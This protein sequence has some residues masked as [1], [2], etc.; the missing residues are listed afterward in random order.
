MEESESDSPSSEYAID[1]N[2]K[3]LPDEIWLHIFS[4]LPQYTILAVIPFVCR[5]FNSLAFD[6]SLW[7]K[8]NLKYSN[9]HPQ[10][11]IA[12]TEVLPFVIDRVSQNARY[13]LFNET[14]GNHVFSSNIRWMYY[15]F[16]NIVHLDVSECCIINA[17]TLNEIRHHC[18]KI[19]TLVLNGCSEV[20]DEA[21]KVVSKFVHLTKLDISE[22]PRITDRGVNFIADMP[23]QILHFLSYDVQWISDGGIVNLVIKQTNIETLVLHGRN[24]TDL[25]VIAACQCLANLKHFRISFCTELTDNSMYALCGKT[26]LRRLYL[27]NITN[28]VSTGAFNLL[29]RYKPLLN[30]TELGICHADAVVD[31]TVNAISSG[32]PNLKIIYLNWCTE[33]TDQSIFNLI[34][35]CR[36]LELLSVHGLAKLKGSWLVGIDHFLP[37]LKHL[38]IPFCGGI[39]NN[40]IKNV[41]LRNKHVVVYSNKID[42]RVFPLGQQFSNHIKQVTLEDF[43]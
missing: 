14:T 36:Q 18:T 33:V 26:G 11:M 4:F 7:R 40:K 17:R 21:M 25:T 31:E 16:S 3:K 1:V 10:F 19:E 29:F 37:K 2:R 20:D 22:C 15:K 5:L 23:C 8:I 43:L 9:Y 35:S 38:L 32:S 28:Q 42:Y 13:L 34:T 6:F 30:L 24:L 41:L 27:R 12:F 39:S